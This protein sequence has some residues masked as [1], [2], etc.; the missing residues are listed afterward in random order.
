MQNVQNAKSRAD[1]IGSGATLAYLRGGHTGWG[2]S[3][4][5]VRDGWRTMHEDLGLAPK[6]HKEM[7]KFAFIKNNGVSRR[8][9][10][11]AR[12]SRKPPVA[13]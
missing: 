12:R 1:F 8:M 9:I 4:D 3:D 11:S 13:A 10:A 7:G 5:G 6:N 2:D